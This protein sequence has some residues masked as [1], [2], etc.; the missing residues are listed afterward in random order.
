MVYYLAVSFIVAEV[1]NVVKKYIAQKGLK[2]LKIWV[3]GFRSDCIKNPNSYF[4]RNKKKDWFNR[5]DVKKVIK[6][7]DNTIAVKDEYFESPVYGGMSPERLPHGCK[8]V[9]LLLI[10]PLCNVYASRCGDNCVPGIL[11]LAEKTDVVITLHHIMGFPE[12]V[13]AEMMDSGKIVNN[14]EEFLE[15]YGKLTGIIE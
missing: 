12:D 8:C 15:E 5:E 6:E 14:R 2:M 11:R 9:I 7:I 1:F 3:E 4:N 13:K 10:N